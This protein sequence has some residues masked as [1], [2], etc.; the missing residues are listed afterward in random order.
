MNL[1]DVPHGDPDIIIHSDT[2]LTGWGCDSALSK[3]GGQWSEEENP[4]HI[5]M[6]EF[7]AALF[8]LRTLASRMDK[9]HITMLDNTTAMAC[10]NNM[11]TNHSVPCVSVVK[12]HMKVLL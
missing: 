8:A 4:L 3:S 9:K 6:L 1:I 5:H 10:I 12:K 7:T 2:S 11:E